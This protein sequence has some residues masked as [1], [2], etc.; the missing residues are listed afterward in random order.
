MP[1]VSDLASYLR[2]KEQLRGPSTVATGEQRAS[3]GQIG[4]PRRTGQP[5]PRRNSQRN[6]LLQGKRAGFRHI[7]TALKRSASL[8]TSRGSR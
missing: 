8:L 1:V 7:Q 6:Q 5:A 2:V 4:R 3:M